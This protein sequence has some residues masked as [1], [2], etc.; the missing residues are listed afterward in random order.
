MPKT[1][2]V[3]LVLENNS[4]AGAI[5]IDDVSMGPLSGGSIT[6]NILTDGG[7]ERHFAKDNPGNDPNADRNLPREFGN[8]FN[9]QT[10]YELDK[11]IESAQANGIKIQLCSCS[12]PWFTWPQDPDIYSWSEPW[13]LK[14]W[15]R[16]FRYRVAR[17]GYSPAVLAWEK[18]NEHGHIPPGDSTY[19]FYQNYGQF[20]KSTDIYHHLRTTSQNSQAYS[21][22]LW[23]SGAMDLANYHDYLDFRSSPYTTM[24]NDEVNLIQRFAWCLTDTRGPSSPYCNGL[25][26][27]D[28]S[29]WSGAAKPWVWGEIGVQQNGQNIQGGEAGARFLHNLVWTGLFSPMGTT[30]LDW[31]QDAEDTTSRNAKYAARKAASTYFSTVDYD[32]GNM[33][34][35]TT[36]NDLPPG[37]SSGAD[38]ILSTNTTVRAYAMRR[39]DGRALYA[40][41]QNRNNIWSKASSAPQAV[42]ATLTFSGLVD[43]TYRLSYFDTRSGSVT[44]TKSVTVQ[45]GTAAVDVTGLSTDLAI[46]IESSSGVPTVAPQPTDTPAVTPTPIMRNGDVN[47]DGSVTVEDVLALFSNW[48]KPATG[49]LDQYIDAIVNTFDYAVVSKNL[50]VVP[51]VAPPTNTPVPI[52]TNTPAPQPSA[53]PTSTQPQP[54]LPPSAGSNE[55]TQFALNAQ[56]TAYT[57]VEVPTPWKWK[58]S[59]NGANASGGVVSGKMSLPRNVQPVTGG[60]RVYVAAGSNGVYAL[61]SSDGSVVWNQRTGATIN[62]TV[63]YDAQ[64]SSVFAVGTNG[65][66]YKLNAANG[67][68]TSS[69]NPNASSIFPLPP[70]ILDNI[71]IYSMGN[72]IH[73]VN[74]ATM[75]RQWY[76]DAGVAIDTPP[77][78]AAN[79]K[80]IIAG[81]RDLYFHGVNAATGARVWRVRP[82]IR[83]E[84]P[85]SGTYG[86]TA[87]SNNQAEVAYGWPVV[88]EANDI[89]LV[90][91]RLDWNT[92]WTW[93]PW[94]TTNAAMRQNLLSNP[95]QQAVFALSLSTG[96]EAFKVNMTGGGF[97]DGDYL[98]MGPMPI[99]KTEANGNEVAYAMIRGDNRTGFDGRDDSKFGE[100]VLN[101]ST[102]SGYEAGD[103]RF[104]AYNNFGWPDGTGL[105]NMPTDEAPYLSMAGN[106]LFGAHWMAG[107]GLIIENRDSSKGT[108]GSPITS[109]SLPHIVNSTNA[110]ATANCTF[111]SSHYC[112]ADTLYQEGDRRSFDGPGFYIYHGS[113]SPAV[114]DQYWVDYASWVISDRI[115]LFRS[116]DGAVVALESGNPLA[117]DTE[118]AANIAGVQSDAKE[119]IEVS[120]PAIIPIDSTL[121]FVGQNKTVEGTIVD[122]FDNKK[123]VYIT[124]ARPHSGTFLARI[125]DE[126]YDKLKGEAMKKYHGNMKVRITGTIDM[127][128]GDPVIYITDLNQIQ[129]VKS[130]GSTSLFDRVLGI[131]TKR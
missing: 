27:G 119:N 106:Y 43:G 68:V 121:S 1:E 129:E 52:S 102:V 86:R 25:G 45:S 105:S 90:T 19:T 112:T 81:A 115:I 8:Y 95:G 57:S 20:Q 107:K 18:H 11:I 84:F 6:Y 55:W 89:V 17:W 41:I 114:Y 103:V 91:Y 22:A 9:Q 127:Y 109:R 29:A 10:S 24:S 49:S 67:Q 28:G 80:M 30:P 36:T 85:S 125:R 111:S 32:G 60:G 74:K 118:G 93:S 15:Q 65:V 42:S 2:A 53:T 50:S 48:F 77:T 124:F 63:A 35:Y 117:K 3:S 47:E 64:T 16:N 71:V 120:G 33:I 83:T 73:A 123:A 82:T 26:L 44:S 79:R 31:F 59:W 4:S 116:T 39:Q 92:I 122:V 62:S 99:V 66:L 5:Y 21:P 72:G 40:W 110:S 58:W 88:S 87:M 94:P 78:Y 38:R 7:I 98:P 75:E 126:A 46:K 37:Y 130:T 100:L 97:G 96:Q 113:Y 108:F 69:Y 34:F 14:S 104:I 128:K 131:F 101:G 51:T 70:L 12:G 61:K 23:S 13:V 56:R 54:T 76:Y